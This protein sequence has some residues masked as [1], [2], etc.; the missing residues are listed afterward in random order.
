HGRRRHRHPPPLPVRPLDRPDATR[1]PPGRGPAG[2]GLAVANSISRN[3]TRRAR[4]HGG[5]TEKDFDL[6][7]PPYLRALRVKLSC[8][9]PDTASRAAVTVL[10]RSIVI[11]IGPTPYGTGER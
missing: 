11:V 8:R 5:A 1:R 9:Y 4:R 3:P 2:S 10:R 7:V 6:R